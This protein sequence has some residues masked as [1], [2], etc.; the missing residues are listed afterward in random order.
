MPT[1]GYRMYN[2]GL[3]FYSCGDNGYYWSSTSN[4]NSKANYL[5]FRSSNVSSNTDNRVNGLPVRCLKNNSVEAILTLN[6][7]GGDVETSM[8]FADVQ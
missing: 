8:I 7:N 3:K 6:P 2:Y 5:F 1:A 4:D